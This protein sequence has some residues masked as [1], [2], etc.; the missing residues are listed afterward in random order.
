M[1]ML[2]VLRAKLMAHHGKAISERTVLDIITEQVDIRADNTIIIH[3]VN[4]VNNVNPQGITVVYIDVAVITLCAL[5]NI[6]EQFYDA[7]HV[8]LR[9]STIIGNAKLFISTVTAFDLDLFVVLVSQYEPSRGFLSEWDRTL[10]SHNKLC[11][12]HHDMKFQRND[13]SGIVNLVVL[14]DEQEDADSSDSD[15]YIPDAAIAFNGLS[16]DDDLI[17]L[18]TSGSNNIQSAQT[19][20]T[21]PTTTDLDMDS[22]TD[23]DLSV[24]QSSDAVATSIVMNIMEQAINDADDVDC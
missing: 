19:Q 14:S 16:D 20:S 8:I 1:S 18:D 6:M 15:L 4:A 9:S 3:D 2:H 12:F 24:D 10:S 21:G 7:N 22:D 13:I 17:N 23:S 5:S 11:V